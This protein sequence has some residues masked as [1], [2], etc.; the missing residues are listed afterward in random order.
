[1][2]TN[3]TA[4]IRADLTLLASRCW[5]AQK[6]VE[7]KRKVLSDI[8]KHPEDKALSIIL[9]VLM[10]ETWNEYRNEPKSEISKPLVLL[11]SIRSAE[12]KCLEVVAQ[13]GKY[14]IAALELKEAEE[15][16][17]SLKK[18]WRDTNE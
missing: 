17:A 4:E 6:D 7:Q 12:R 1:M 8:A 15:L 18:E 13:H 11:S 10:K 9:H 3:H 16:E 14:D 5:L 2:Q